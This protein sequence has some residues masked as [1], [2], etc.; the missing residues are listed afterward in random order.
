MKRL[1]ILILSLMLGLACSSTRIIDSWTAPGLQAGDLQFKQI[2]VVAIL[3]NEGR[4][5]VAE[6]AFISAAESITAKPAYSLLSHTDLADREKAKAALEA[7][8]ADGA[9]V[10]RFVNS[11][12]RES[13]V[14]GTTRAPG[15]MWGHYHGS[16][17]SVHDPGY[18][19]T[20]V[21]VQIETSLYDLKKDKLLWSAVSETINPV[22]VDHVITGI[23]DAATR[24]LKKEGLRP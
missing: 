16:W 18:M 9:V 1:S 4:R 15:G 23:V 7:A 5:R 2:V 11:G 19:R 22:S 10:I 14:P 24:Q 8:G 6:D 13:Y 17:A 3:S 20:D 21:Y 12:K